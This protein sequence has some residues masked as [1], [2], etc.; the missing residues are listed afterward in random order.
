MKKRILW[1]FVVLCL[2]GSQKI[3]S[4]ACELEHLRSADNA[5]FYPYT[6]SGLSGAY[7]GG[8]FFGGYQTCYFIYNSNTGKLESFAGGLIMGSLSGES[9]QRSICAGDCKPQAPIFRKVYEPGCYFSCNTSIESVRTTDINSTSNNWSSTGTWNDGLVPDISIN[10]VIIG[11]SINIDAN[12]VLSSPM[13]IFNSSIIN[14]DANYIFSCNSVMRFSGS[15]Q[16]INYGTLQGTGYIIANFSNLGHCGP[17]N[18]PG[19]LTITGN[20]TAQSSAVHD[21]EI[22]GTSSY[23]VLNISGTAILDGALNVSLLG[24]F[25]PN[26]GDQFTLMT[27]ASKTGTFASVNL[28]SLPSG[29]Y[30]RLIYN[31]TNLVLEVTNVLAVELLSFKAQNVEVRNP[32]TGGTE[33]GNLLTW[34]TANEINNKGFQVERRQSTGDSWDILGFVSAK[35]KT[36]NY[37][38]TDDY[39]LPPVAYYRLRQIDNDGKETLSKIIAVAKR[40]LNNLKAYPS[41]TNGVL[42]I[43]TTETGSYSIVNL[44]G[45]Q[46][47][48]GKVAQRIDVS[49]L[50]KGAYFLKVGAEQVKFLKQ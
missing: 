38:F 16:L 41:V 18:S 4:Q 15:G 22:A 40:G 12:L 17:G 48:N 19:T 47:Q 1:S 46:V 23:D 25:V 43:E 14:I 44:L 28:P 27:Y 42:T 6:P 50:P 5:I 30:W 13:E 45:Q 29:R 39:R 3:F 37:T 2:L 34:Q 8:E 31:S 10:P 21:M 20:Y 24:G 36:T 32:A 35:G 49:V 9:Y 11:K 26:I 7:T 33:G